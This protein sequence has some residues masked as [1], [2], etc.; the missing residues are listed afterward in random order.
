MTADGLTTAEGVTTADGLTTAEGDQTV[1]GPQASTGGAGREAIQYHYDIS[2]DFY[3]LWL[4]SRMVYSCA[5][6]PGDFD[7]DFDAAQVAK[8]EWHATAMRVDGGGRALDVGCG[9]GAMLGYLTEERHVGHVTGL[10]LSADQAAAVTPSDR[11][12]VRLEDW[13]DHRP[14]RPYDAIVSI[15]AFEHFARHDL[16]QAERR[17][18]Y[19]SF[20]ERCGEWLD[21]GG[22]LSLQ[23]IAHEDFD[24]SS[25]LPSSFFVDQIFPESGLPQLSDIVETAEPVFR[26]VGFRNDGEHYEHTLRLWQQRLESRQDE[27]CR[28]VGRDTYRRYVR[29]LRVSRAMFARRLCTLNRLVLERRRASSPRG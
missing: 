16:A 24:P 18:V 4:D 3:R 5:L 11:V 28:L 27:A 19:R 14:E 2:R 22:R 15:G 9:W 1:P 29:Y 20:F 25:G 26:L 13:R 6:W 8:L 7:E 23:T 12:E 21:E 10:T 17:A